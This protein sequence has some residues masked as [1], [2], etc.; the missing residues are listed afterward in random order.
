GAL[1][2]L[3]VGAVFGGLL[4][5]SDH[6]AAAY[7]VW[8]IAGAIS[9][10]S[11]ASPAARQMI[12]GL[13]ARFGRLVGNAV[14]A[15]ILTFVYFVVVT[16]VR[17]F[18]RAA[19]TDTLHLR[20]R[21]RVSYWLPCDDPHRKA[22]WAGTMFATEVPTR[23]GSSVRVLLAS[24]VVL[25]LLTEGILRLYGF[26]QPLLYLADPQVGYYPQPNAHLARYGG[27]V[28]TNQYGMRSAEVTKQKPAGA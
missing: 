27:L 18:R 8:G 16:P 3:V 2:K 20:D 6:R 24:V 21:D 7:V 22:K 12:D 15:V 28:A 26:G 14:G 19:G 1:A 4:Y 9:G 25:F 13:L 11:L 23:S 5:V 17:F 10:I